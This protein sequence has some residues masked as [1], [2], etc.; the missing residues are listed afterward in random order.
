MTI[1]SDLEAKFRLLAVLR[2]LFPDVME[3]TVPASRNHQA[4]RKFS[5]VR[6]EIQEY[7]GIDEFN[8]LFEPYLKKIEH[9]EA[10]EAEREEQERKERLSLLLLKVPCAVVRQNPVGHGGFHT[11]TLG[12]K[13]KRLHWVYDCGSWRKK[14]NLVKC[15][16]DF[17]STL[18]PSDSLVCGDVRP[19]LENWDPAAYD[20]AEAASKLS[21]HGVGV[22]DGTQRIRSRF[23]RTPSAAVSQSCATPRLVLG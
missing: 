5:Q 1:V 15:V 17:S 12:I 7:I 20:I 6:K 2:R 22:S 13:R 11:G 10:V 19:T 16:Q 21:C 14:D 9:D 3:N 23:G 18:A 8:R 4:R